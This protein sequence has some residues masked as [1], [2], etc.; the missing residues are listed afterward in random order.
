MKI[1]K[2]IV[3]SMPEAMAK[4]K[5]ELGPDAVILNSKQIKTGGIFGLFKK[6]K[7]EVIAALDEVKHTTTNRATNKTAMERKLTNVVTKQKDDN[8]E[9]LLQEIR[10]LRKMLITN[11]LQSKN[12]YPPAF[13]HIFS[14]LVKHDVTEEIAKQIVEEMIERN[15]KG[16]TD[17]VSLKDLLKTTIADLLHVDSGISFDNKVIQ[18]VGP[19]GVGKT[20]TLAK[21][22]A[23][24]VLQHKKKIAFITTDTYRIAAIDQ[25]KTYAKILDVPVKIAYTLEEYEEALQ[26]F[27]TYDLVFVDTAGRN[28]RDPQY[29]KELERMHHFHKHGIETYLVLSLTAKQSDM[30]ATYEQFEHLP[31]KKV[32]LTKLD[33]TASYG[34]ILNINIGKNTPIA[35]ITNGQNVPDDIMTPDRQR[36]SDLLVSRYEN[37]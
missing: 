35:Y 6:K 17:D 34:N 3:N 36:L 31:I 22:A 19:T 24:S 4:I 11:S 1:K 12:D 15:E 7:I 30:L 27:A 21:V 28:F 33:E 25:L 10:E 2:F 23:L 14:Y 37:A 13:E 18:F 26:S 16:E 20:T 9:T 32:I 29:V 8:D 5:K